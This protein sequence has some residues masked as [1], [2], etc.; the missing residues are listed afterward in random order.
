MRPKKIC[1]VVSSPLTARAFL[2]SHLAV[3][4][5]DYEIDLVADTD[6][7]AELGDAGKYARLSPAPIRRKISPWSDFCGLMALTSLFRRER[8]AA[9]TSVTPKAG[10]LALLAGWLTRAPVRIHIFTGQVW[11]TRRG[12]K[13][14]LLKAVDWLMARL[15]THTLT[16][17]PSQRDFLI[18]EGVVHADRIQVLGAGSICGVDGKRFRPSAERRA[19]VRTRHAIPDDAV[20]FLYL[21]RLNCDKGVLDLAEA[22]A[23]VDTPSA[24]LLVVGPDEAGLRTEMEMR[25]GSNLPHACF[26]GFTNKPEDYISAADVFCLPSYR[27]GFGTVII[28]AAA[29]GLPAIA[30]RIYGVTDAVAEGITGVLH[31]PHDIGAI[32]AAIV[33]LAADRKRCEEMGRAARERA[34]TLYSVAAIT[35]AW[36]NYY[37]QLL[38]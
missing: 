28:E 38:D 33:S 18:A 11:A 17:S 10:L 30:S 22:F 20:V 19:A 12:W 7:I 6:N 5:S 24:R 3:M 36:R 14:A 4:S 31:A 23:G 15:A 1:F 25:I 32:R 37:A 2:S 29:A 34:E 35:E 8:Y 9:I 27:E 13:R 16:D 26:V 21:G